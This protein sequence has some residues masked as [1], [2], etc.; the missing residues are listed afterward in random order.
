MLQRPLTWIRSWIKSPL[1][2]FF[3]SLRAKDSTLNSWFPSSGSF[4]DFSTLTTD[5][6]PIGDPAGF[7]IPGIKAGGHLAKPDQWM[8]YLPGH[9]KH[10]APLLAQLTSKKLEPWHHSCQG[11]SWI[12]PR[13]FISKDKGSRPSC[14]SAHLDWRGVTLTMELGSIWK[15]DQQRPGAEKQRQR[16]CSSKSYLAGCN[17][18]FQMREAIRRH[19]KEQASRLLMSS[20]VSLHRSPNLHPQ[21]RL[22]VTLL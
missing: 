9:I 11:G 1:L 21:C 5:Q 17:D 16:S 14:E 8:C 7:S 12:L 15:R 6:L 20:Q 4:Q 18:I 2:S 3:P 10:K 19:S 22:V 13:N